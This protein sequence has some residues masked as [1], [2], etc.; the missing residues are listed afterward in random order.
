MLMSLMVVLA[1]PT[2]MMTVLM[3]AIAVML[4]MVVVVAVLFVLTQIHDSIRTACY[5][6]SVVVPHDDADAA[7]ETCTAL[8]HPLKQL[9]V[10][11]LPAAPS[12]D[13]ASVVPNMA[14]W[15]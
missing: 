13:M 9:P 14:L 2:P 10:Y 11:I 5:G 1:M 8:P 6:G 12:V 4:V 3:I 7:G 15:G